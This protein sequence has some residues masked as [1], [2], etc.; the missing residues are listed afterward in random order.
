MRKRSFIKL[1]LLA[2]LLVGTDSGS[3]AMAQDA[4][5]LRNI[6]IDDY[7]A[8]KS[9]GGPLIS[10][11]GVWVVYTI[12]TKDL[13]NDRS[14]SR[15]WMIATAGGAPRPMTAKGS[16]FGAPVGAPTAST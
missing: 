1:T 10:P 3:W 16:S 15:L 5:T 6:Q 7:F 2:L 12:R 14:E 4:V 9:V 13:E 8:L 11:D